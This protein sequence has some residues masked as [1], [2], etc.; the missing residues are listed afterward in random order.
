M[1]DTVYDLPCSKQDDPKLLD[2]GVEIPKSQ[3]KGW[4][5]NFWLCNLLS[6]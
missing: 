3:G 1:H 6:T 2:D 4:Q 5:V